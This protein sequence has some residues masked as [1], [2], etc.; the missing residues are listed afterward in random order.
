MRT[1]SQKLGGVW[2]DESGVT[3]PEVLTVVA[4]LGILIAIAII[5]WLGILERRRVD[6]ASRQLAADMR[7]AYSSST[8]QLTDWRLVLAPERAT[9]GDGADYYLV[10][11][12]AAYPAVSPPTV[13]ESIP[14]YFPANV[15]IRDYNP[16]LNDNQADSGWVS[17]ASTSPS[18]TR[19]LEFNA[20]GTM[21]FKSGPNGSVCITI[22]GDPERKVT[23]LSATSRVKIKN[24]TCS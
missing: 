3:L 2:K 17:P 22:D 21:A 23:A 8:D 10:R 18:S 19:T 7:W 5:V 13:A 1:S 4:I 6:A 14:R 12:S 20:D 15:K 9:E 24:E 11:L 16:A